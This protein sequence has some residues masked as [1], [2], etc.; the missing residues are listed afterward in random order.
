MNRQIAKGKI[1]MFNRHEMVEL[2]TI[3]GKA[4]GII[5]RNLETGKLERPRP[6][7]GNS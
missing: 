6:R 1:Q 4:R 3:D 5:A 2:V 7:G